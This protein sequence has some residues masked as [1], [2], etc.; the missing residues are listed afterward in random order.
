[1]SGLPD[2][3]RQG[4]PARLIPVAASGQ[5]ERQACSVLLAVLSVVQ[6]FARQVFRHMGYR[7]GRRAW[8]EAYTE[9]VFKRESLEEG[10]G[11]PDGLLVL[12]TSQ[13]E[14]RALVE[15][16]IGN[17]RLDVQ[18]LLRYHKI[19]K[20]NGLD[21]IIT[22]SNELTPM[23]D[24]LPYD[25]PREMIGDIE[26]YHWP[27]ST[28][29]M[30]ASMLIKEEANFDEEQHFILKEAVRYLEHQSSD[31]RG[32]NAMAPS[33]PTLVQRL[34]AG[35][36]VGRDDPDVADALRCWHQ[37]QASFC[38]TLSRELG[39]LVTLK[40]SRPH[41]EQ[42]RLRWSEDLA[43]FVASKRLSL[44]FEV[45]GAAGPLDLVADILQRNVICRLSVDAPDTPR[46][47][48]GKMNWLLR[49]LP[50]ESDAST[51]VHIIWKNGGRTSA[52]LHAIRSDLD[53]A[54]LDRSGAVP[55][56]FEIIIASDLD[57]RFPG[58][59]TF[60]A[61]VEAALLDF[62]E[63]VARHIRPPRPQR[64][65]DETEESAEEVADAWMSSEEPP[66]RPTD[67]VAG[68]WMSAEEQEPEAKPKE[69]GNI[70]GRMFVIFTDGSVEIETAGGVKRFDSVAEMMAAARR[71]H[72]GDGRPPL[73]PPSE[74][75]PDLP[76]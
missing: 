69:T 20:D 52:P 25:P 43:D 22:I 12:A 9:I 15:A 54:R 75:S 47:Y 30:M 61:A 67:E 66:A 37:A 59:Q 36:G 21:A 7:M 49:Q 14:W 17:G 41:R 1:V 40:L 44:D 55:R 56:Y 33:W 6:P 74:P 24:H 5:R 50:A 16:K 58:P 45:P 29:L 64:S 63:T 51:I 38:V 76:I 4:E 35:A 53:V 70:D 11:R 34:R 65:A 2:F 19:A 32:F 10:A 68:S 73:E 42:Q 18:Q 23:P 13:G 57:R 31:I 39:T 72:N 26:L 8:V 48:A 60:P 71:D 27:W 3:L 46:Q 62:Y 28:L